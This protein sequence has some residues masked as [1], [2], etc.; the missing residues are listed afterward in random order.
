[1]TRTFGIDTSRMGE[2]ELL[3]ALDGRTTAGRRGYRDVAVL[4]REILRINA[5][6]A[7][8]RVTHARTAV[9]RHGP[10]GT[11]LKP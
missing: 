5:Y 7:R 6:D 2:A 8:Q 4:T 11:P 3:A 9:A 10:T 1:M